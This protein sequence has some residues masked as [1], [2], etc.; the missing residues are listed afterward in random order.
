LAK[1]V[2]DTSR[3]FGVRYSVHPSLWAALASHFRW[4]R[5]MGAPEPVG[6]MAQL[7]YKA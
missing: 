7:K 4:L 6:A 2:E 3:E 1:L 5:G